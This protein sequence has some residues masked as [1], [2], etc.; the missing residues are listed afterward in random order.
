MAARILAQ[1]IITGT[2]FLSKAFLEGYRQALNNAKGVPNSAASATSR[3]KS[4]LQIN[5]ALNILNIEKNKLSKTVLEERY[6]KLFE[7]NDPKKG[8]SFYLQSKVFRAKE[9]L[10]QELHSP[11]TASNQGTS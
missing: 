1:L 10:D 7:L 5:E 6:A 11:R 8:G 2:T 4:K 9:A 3:T